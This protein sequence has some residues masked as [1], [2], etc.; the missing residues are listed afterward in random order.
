MGETKDSNCAFDSIWGLALTV[1]A[2]PKLLLDWPPAQAPSNKVA[3]ILTAMQ[4]GFFGLAIKVL[5]S[6]IFST[7]QIDKLF[8]HLRDDLTG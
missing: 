6:I 7:K 5:W 2:F 8:C 1:A 3:A 4:M